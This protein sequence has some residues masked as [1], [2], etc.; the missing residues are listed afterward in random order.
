MGVISFH[1]FIRLIFFSYLQPK[2]T[3]YLPDIST[4]PSTA[5]RIC[6][7]SLLPL[8]ISC[9]SLGTDTQRELQNS[10]VNSRIEICT[11]Y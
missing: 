9:L 8:W 11:W 3:D 10:G 1:S 4:V 6:Q 7:Q 5:G 2:Y